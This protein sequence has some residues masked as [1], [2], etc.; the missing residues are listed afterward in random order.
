MAGIKEGQ[1]EAISPLLDELLEL[2]AGQQSLRLAELRRHDPQL[3]ETVAR[4]L[5]QQTE[6]EREAFLH[7][8]IDVHGL[9]RVDASGLAGH[10]TGSYTLERLLGQ[11]GMGSV[12]LAR[13]NDGRYEGKA[14]LKLLNLALI[15]RG[16]AQRFQRE[17]S[18]LA[19][20]THPNI[21]RLIDAGVAEGQPYLVLEYVEGEAIDHWCDAQALGV[22]ARIRLFMDVLAAVAHA[23]NNLTLHRDLKPSNI[24]VDS[25]GRVK[26]LDFGIAKLIEDPGRPTA[27]TELTQLAGRAFTPE[28]AAPE[29]VEGRDVT[30]ATDVYSLGVLLYVLL[31]GQHPT[32]RANT[33]AVDQLRSVL[34]TE[35]QRLSE[36]ARRTSV[37]AAGARATTPPRLA[38]DLRGDLDNIVAKALKKAPAERYPNA[39]ALAED[40]RRYLNDQPVEARPDTVGYRISKFV[41]RYRLTVGAASATLLALTAGV[42]GTTWQAIEARHERDE[43]RFQAERALA[44]GELVSL[45]LSA[46]GDTNRPLTQREILDRSVILVEKQFTRNPRIAVDLLLP[47]AGQYHT[48]GEVEKE[49]AIMQRASVI[50]AATGDPLLIADVACN[51]VETRM[52]RGEMAL[53]EE[54]LRIGL[55]ALDQIT[56]PD[57]GTTSACL[58]ADAEIAQG[59]GDLDRALKSVTDA[60][61]RVERVGETRG[62]DSPRL[63]SFLSALHLRR[64]ELAASYD[65][66]R[67]LQRLDEESGRTETVDFLL[68]RRNDAV[69]LAAMG[70]YR[71]ARAILDSLAPRWREVTGDDAAPPWLGQSR[72]RLMLTFG[73]LDEARRLLEET[74]RRYQSQ[75]NADRAAVAEFS[76][77]QVYVQQGQFKDA[78]RLLAS[79]E[80][81][82][83]SATRRYTFNTPATVRATLHLAQGNAPEAAR[84]IEEELERIRQTPGENAIVRAAA[85]RVAAR[86]YLAANDANRAL[87]FAAAARAA[88][89]L[90]ARDPTFSA[91][92]G[93]ALLLLAQAQRALGKTGEAAQTAQSAARSLTY[94][95]GEEHKLTRAARALAAS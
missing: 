50:A 76:L 51:T 60:I 19:R 14:A 75:G 64:G 88:S 26:L 16:G 34:E 87:V 6:V 66:S 56:R 72:G 85:L 53:A 31:G 79:V 58:Q 13:R 55:A 37:D 15:N 28:Y 65:V 35:P 77:A 40:L 22:D 42:V 43:A 74:V 78:E 44:K 86:V 93:E 39:A 67:R 11:G 18:I 70:E 90:A 36:V 54:Q 49:L 32:A 92:V 24:L 41:R 46:M 5:A 68:E 29:Q 71:G 27:A 62:N 83:T 20:L 4:L 89:E 21:A 2:D 3:A 17:G 38:R 80:S 73:E 52:R 63:L 69:L 95:L 25:D 30:T 7:G 48:L 1:W 33:A 81:Q 91:D 8:A 10:V 59:Q 45:M 57:V 12:W 23:H 47:I 61:A 9:E 82:R 94:G 84:L